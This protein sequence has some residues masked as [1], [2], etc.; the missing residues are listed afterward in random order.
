MQGTLDRATGEVNLDFSAQFVFTAGPIY[1]AAPLQ[2]H[3]N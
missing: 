2:V 3:T 1:E